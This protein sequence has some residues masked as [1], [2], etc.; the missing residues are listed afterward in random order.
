MLN[1]L[2]PSINII[3]NEYLGE[4]VQVRFPKP[5]KKYKQRTAKRFARDPRNWITRG[6]GEFFMMDGGRTVM[7][8]PSDIPLLRA[9]LAA[10]G[11]I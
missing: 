3:A 10:R 5:P 7:C 8:H 2:L 6:K 11:L 9:Q 1:A 4:R